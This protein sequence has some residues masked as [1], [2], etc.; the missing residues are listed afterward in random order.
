MTGFTEQLP[1]NESH[2]TG[3]TDGLQRD[4]PIREDRAVL[5]MIIRLPN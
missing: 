1:L 3:F 4:S 5:L 2:N